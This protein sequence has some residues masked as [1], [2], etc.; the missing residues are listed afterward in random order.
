MNIENDIEIQAW[1]SFKD[2]IN[3]FLSNKRQAICDQ[4]KQHAWKVTKS[5]M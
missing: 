5:G 2:V 4:C 1:S 3:T